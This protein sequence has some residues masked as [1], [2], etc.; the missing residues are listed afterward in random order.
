MGIEVTNGTITLGTEWD[1]KLFKRLHRFLLAHE[2][3][4]VS[5]WQG[6]AGSQDVRHLKYSKNGQEIV[7]ESETYKGITLSGDTDELHKLS[8]ALETWEDPAKKS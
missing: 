2:Y 8:K 6:M 1:D 4:H 3:S 7:M 5:S